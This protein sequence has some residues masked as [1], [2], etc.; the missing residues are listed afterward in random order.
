MK[1]RPLFAI[2]KVI[3]EW[4]LGKMQVAQMRGCTER[5]TP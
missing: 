2:V 1:R 5:L 3:K 4:A